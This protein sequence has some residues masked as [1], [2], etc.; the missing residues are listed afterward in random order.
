M[1]TRR[2]KKKI[3]EK[4]IRAMAAKLASALHPQ[5]IYLFGSYAWGKPKPESDVDFCLVYEKLTPKQVMP[6]LTKAGDALSEFEDISCDVIIRNAERM[7][8]LRP[9]HAPLESKILRRGKLLFELA[10]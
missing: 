2:A 5:Q 10:R 8:G 3:P 1:S 7:E 9:Y 4:T 6:L